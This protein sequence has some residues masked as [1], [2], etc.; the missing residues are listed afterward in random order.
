MIQFFSSHATDP[1][2]YFEL[3]L[4]GKVLGSDSPD[5][6]M[7]LLG[8]LCDWVDSM[9]VASSQIAH[10]EELLASENLPSFS[11]LRVADEN[12]IRKI[13]STTRK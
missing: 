3:K 7:A 1:H 9:G 8:N 5:E 13:F 2:R 6:L 10:L 12:E 4:T 11:S